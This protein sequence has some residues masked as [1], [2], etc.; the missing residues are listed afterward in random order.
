MPMRFLFISTVYPLAAKDDKEL[1][2]PPS[3]PMRSTSTSSGGAEE[4]TGKPANADATS[5]TDT[6]AI[7]AKG[8]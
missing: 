5:P 2:P 6:K 7:D 4:S 1:M 8:C 3:A